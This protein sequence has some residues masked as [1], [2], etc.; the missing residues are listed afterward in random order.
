MQ[1]KLLNSNS[2]VINVV[3]S[4]VG[5]QGVLVASDVL[6]AVAMFAGLDSKKSEVH[7]M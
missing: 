7:G 4:G 1:N 2:P 3:L 6:V 5:G